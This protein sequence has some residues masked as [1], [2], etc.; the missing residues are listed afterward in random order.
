[1]LS[2]VRVA[3]IEPWFDRWRVLVTM[4]DDGV[5]ESQFIRFLTEPTQQQA[6]A[7]GAARVAVLNVE[8]ADR[9]MQE[10]IENGTAVRRYQTAGE[11]AARFRAAYLVAA[12][13]QTA[14]MA[15]W[16]IE[17]IND[18]TFTDVQVRSAFGLTTTQY[19]AM[20]AR[21]TTL[22]DEWAGVLAA[23]GE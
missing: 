13:Q 16:L 5:E 4:S 12:R 10:M 22:H 18:G 23:V 6:A 11:L 20:K 9:E 15:Y 21:A 14:K 1:M 8:R 2:F 19:T 3:R 7:A 17:R